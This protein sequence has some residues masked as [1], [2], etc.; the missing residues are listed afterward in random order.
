MGSEAGHEHGRAV[1]IY[2]DVQ[3]WLQQVFVCATCVLAHCI[4]I[5]APAWLHI[6]PGRAAMRWFARQR[7]TLLGA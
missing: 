1:T 3:S 4:R 2:R 6:V 7:D 5:S